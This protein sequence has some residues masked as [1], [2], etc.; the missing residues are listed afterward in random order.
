MLNT[1]VLQDSVDSGRT[2]FL[3]GTPALA[4]EFASCCAS[5]MNVG[6]RLAGGSRY[7]TAVAGEYDRLLATSSDISPGGSELYVYV[8]SAIEAQAQ[9]AIRPEAIALAVFGVIAGLAAL[10][11]GIQ[12]IS[13]QLRAG[14]DDAGALRALGA[15]P[16]MIM[17]DGL[18]GSWRRWWPG[19]C[20]PPRWRPR[21]RR[22]RCSGRS[23]WLTRAAAST[24]TGWCSGWACSGWFSCSAG[25]RRSSATAR[26]RTAWPPAKRRCRKLAVSEQTFYA[27]KKKYSGMGAVE[28]R[29]VS[30]LAI[31]PDALSGS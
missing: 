9:R 12:S 21:C 15:G 8:T 31:G 19:R 11:I 3:I 4:R 20:S 26:R 25:R 16:A 23:G 13:R 22:S 6:L 27:W 1:Q 14:A 7:D 5:G 10:M 17:A 30:Q 18:P 28:L 2:G 24:S 29:R